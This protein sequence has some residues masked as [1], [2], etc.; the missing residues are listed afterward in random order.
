MPLSHISDVMA[1]SARSLI[2]IEN[3]ILLIHSDIR[4]KVEEMKRVQQEL[5]NLVSQRDALLAT[6]SS[7]TAFMERNKRVDY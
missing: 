7:L 3:E 2:S 4:G 6:A 1:D 5:S